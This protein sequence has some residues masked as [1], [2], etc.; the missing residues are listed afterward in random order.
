[1]RFGYEQVNVF[2][3]DYVA[4]YYKA[5]TIAHQLKH[6]EEKIAALWRAQER[7]ALVTAGRDEVQSACAVVTP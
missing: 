2:R 7:L 4:D 6:L 3:H 5:V 1:L